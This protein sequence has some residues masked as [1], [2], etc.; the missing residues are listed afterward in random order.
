MKKVTTVMYLKIP[1][2]TDERTKAGSHIILEGAEE[3][4][5]H[6]SSLL[7]QHRYA[8]NASLARCEGS[9]H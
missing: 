6:S 1:H 7:D 8:S 9:S 4:N 2:D 5:Q 3:G